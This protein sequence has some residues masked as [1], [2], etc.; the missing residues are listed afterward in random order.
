M[1][2]KYP[3]TKRGGSTDGHLTHGSEYIESSHYELCCS[4]FPTSAT[5]EILDTFRPQLCPFDSNTICT[6]L[7]M[8]EWFL[9][10]SLPPEKSCFGHQLWFHEFM[11]LWEVCHNAPAWEGDMMR[12]MA[13]LA[14][15]NIGYIDWEPYIPL[16]FTRFLHSLKL[17]VS[18]QNVQYT[19]HHKLGVGAM[20]L[21]IISVLVS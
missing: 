17:P 4:Y 10:I 21:W 19:K 5:Q 15:C 18:Y 16:M 11:H 14:R 8:L 20:A 9:P 2:Y 12:L 3:Q 6:A 7:Q 1:S 13:R